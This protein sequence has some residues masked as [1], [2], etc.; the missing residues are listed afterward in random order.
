MQVVLSGFRVRL[1]CFVQP[2][3]LF[4][5]GGMYVLAELLFMC[6]DVMMMPS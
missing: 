1:L 4:W 3:T 5:Y 6:V 2:K